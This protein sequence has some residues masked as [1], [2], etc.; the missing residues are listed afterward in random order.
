MGIRYFLIDADSYVGGSGSGNVVAGSYAVVGEGYADTW[1][2]DPGTVLR[3][4]QILAPDGTSLLTV[5]QLGSSLR[6]W[7][8]VSLV[9]D[10][11][12]E[13]LSH[14]SAAHLVSDADGNQFVL[15]AELP[16][17]NPELDLTGRTPDVIQINRDIKIQRT[18]GIQGSMYQ[19]SFGGESPICFAA[20]TRIATPEGDRMVEQL[21][22]GD[23]VL[24]SGGAVLP[25]LWVGGRRLSGGVLRAN[26]KWAPIRIEPGALAPGVPARPLTVSPQH[27]ILLTGE[28]VAHRLRHRAVFVPARGLLGLPGVAVLRPE[29]GIAYHH[30]LLPRHAALRAD[31]APAESLL[32]TGRS[33][34][35]LSPADRATVA[36]LVVRHGLADT[37]RLPCLTTGQA[38]RAL[39]PSGAAQRSRAPA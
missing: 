27:R 22:P 25:V 12:P 16:S 1:E 3:G 13:G 2:D 28:R 9:F 39:C 14:G 4:S 31:G 19:G 38:R 8:A 24:T 15:I 11:G 5:N 33:L 29:D 21:R 20:G 17:G 34:A 26:P 32:P 30:L 6:V 7:N 10:G 18:A 23:R 36:A 35:S 37:T